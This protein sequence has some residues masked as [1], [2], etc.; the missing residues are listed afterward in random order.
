MAG[1]AQLELF[2]RRMV[3]RIDRRVAEREAKSAP[4]PPVRRQPER[5]ATV[6]RGEDRIARCLREAREHVKRQSG[7]LYRGA[8]SRYGTLEHEARR[9]HDAAVQVEFH[10]RLK[11]I[12]IHVEGADDE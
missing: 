2:A 5:A 11:A 3:E 6:I 7:Q 10:R 9:R 8:Y 4:P 1:S 12:G